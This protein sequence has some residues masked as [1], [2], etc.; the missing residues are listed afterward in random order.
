M[1]KRLPIFILTASSRLEDVERAFDLG[2]NAYLVKPGNLDELIE[3]AKCLHAWINL[4]HF[5][6]L[7]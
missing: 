4:N 6:P 7:L 1:L 5:A 2:A 3:M